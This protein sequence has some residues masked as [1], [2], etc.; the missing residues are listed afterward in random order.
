MGWVETIPFRLTSENCWSLSFTLFC[1][2]ICFITECT[3]EIKQCLQKWQTLYLKEYP[4][5]QSLS[6]LLLRACHTKLAG[7]LFLMIYSYFVYFTIFHFKWGLTI[8]RWN[9]GDK[10]KHGPALCWSMNYVKQR[11]RIV[12]SCPW[13]CVCVYLTALRLKSLLLG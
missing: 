1:C 4:S 6:S 8:T 11:R 12:S 13:T 5:A 2:L 9:K 3:E 7:R 10:F